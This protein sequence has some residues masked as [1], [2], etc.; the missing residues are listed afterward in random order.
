MSQL[1]RQTSE[2]T[3]TYV[4]YWQNMETDTY[5]LQIVLN[6]ML[7]EWNLFLNDALNKTKKVN[8]EPPTE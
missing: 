3:A 6:N 4:Y 8:R 7:G 2:I 1:I 5:N